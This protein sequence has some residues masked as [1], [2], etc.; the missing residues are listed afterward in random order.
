MKTLFLFVLLTL[1]V[2][3]TAQT[4]EVKFTSFICNDTIKGEFY[5][6]PYIANLIA[7]V[8]LGDSSVKVADD[9]KEWLYLDVKILNAKYW[10]D[11]ELS[12][13]CIDPTSRK[14]WDV[15]FYKKNGYDIMHA[16][17]GKLIWI[18]KN[19]SHEK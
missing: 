16:K 3:C 19:P 4:Y 13:H 11:G 8:N 5:K 15:N 1:E 7:I 17:S 2:M 10:R 18:F 14:Y 12:V 6:D 9:R